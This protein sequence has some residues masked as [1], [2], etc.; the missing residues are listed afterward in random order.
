MSD[1]EERNNRRADEEELV[2][3]AS[4][5]GAARVAGKAAW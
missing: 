1:G 4:F 5:A 3:T 2:P